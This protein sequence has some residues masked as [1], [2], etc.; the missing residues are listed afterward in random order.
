M[1]ETNWGVIIVAVVVFAYLA[2]D[3]Y[4]GYKLRQSQNEKE[5]GK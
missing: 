4:L 2:F 1:F 5:N 3:S